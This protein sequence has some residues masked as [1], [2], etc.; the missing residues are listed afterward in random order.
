MAD[1]YI[2][3]MNSN[4]LFNS[5]NNADEEFRS[6]TIVLFI[7]FVLLSGS[8]SISSYESFFESSMQNILF[9]IIIICILIVI[10]YNI[11]NILNLQQKNCDYI[12]NQY[13]S[14]NGNI[15]SITPDFSGNLS[16]YYIKTAYN[17]CSGGSY[18]NDYVDICV[19]KAII[20]QGVRCL[21]F[22]IY[23]IDN[24]PV[25]ASSTSTDFFIK[26][27]FNYVP[28]ENVMKTINDYAFTSGTCQNSD[29]PI[30]L[31]LRIKSNNQEMFTNMAKIFEKYPMVGPEYS[32]ND[33]NPQ[34]GITKNIGSESLLKFKNKILLI[35]DRTNTSFLEN[36][37]L[38]EFVNMCSNSIYM[39]S[40]KSNDISLIKNDNNLQNE[41]K[42][43]NVNNLSIV[44]PDN[45]SNPY[46]PNWAACE[47]LGCQMVAMRYQY[48]DDYLKT[49]NKAFDTYNSAFRLKSEE[50]RTLNPN[51]MPSENTILNMIIGYKQDSAKSAENSAKSAQESAKSAQESANYSKNSLKPVVTS[52]NNTNAQSKS[53]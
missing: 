38:L 48:D 45:G 39:R 4:N 47:E 44:L 31:H 29:D 27:T 13:P 32:Y 18:S 21:D 33:T 9:I 17:A 28:F 8:Q 43:F 34:S 1:Q 51:L 35:V 49:Y 2:N 7:F 11:I 23:S 14:I 16:N 3:L 10:I 19:L 15:I 5:Y 53:V 12:N 22:E 50:L 6:Y 36:E 30:I 20:K 41:L 24:K 52:S 42:N 40:F 37:A 25:V 46:N 26:E